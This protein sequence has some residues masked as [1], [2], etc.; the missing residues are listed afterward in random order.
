[1]KQGLPSGDGDGF[2]R[3]IV[4]LAQQRGIH[5]VARKLAEEVLP[6]GTWVFDG[7]IE[8]IVPVG[9]VANVAT[10]ASAVAKTLSGMVARGYMPVLDEGRWK[11][12]MEAIS[13]IIIGIGG[14]PSFEARVQ[15][16]V[17]VDAKTRC[18]A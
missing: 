6:N 13:R 15:R 11:G 1:M 12:C 9:I 10:L 5:L 8:I 4:R 2:K 18:Q 14:Q 3:L 16:N 17:R 7:Q